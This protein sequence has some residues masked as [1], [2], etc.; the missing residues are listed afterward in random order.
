MALAGNFPAPAGN[1]QGPCPVPALP[2]E[3]LTRLPHLHREARRNFGEARLLAR[4]PAAAMLLMTA[5]ALV[6]LICGLPG[7]GVTIKAGFAWSALLL[8]GIAAMTRNYIRG[9]ARAL[10]RVPL[11]AAAADL[12]AIL[13]YTGLA[14]GAGA[15]LVMPV[16]AFA[17]AALAFAVLPPLALVLLLRDEGAAAAFTVPVALLGAGAALMQA[18]QAGLAAA[19]VTADLAVTFLPHL[20]RRGTHL[21]G[22]RLPAG[23]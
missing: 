7:E 16:T 23:R 13:L 2:R 11:P 17:A 12:R 15:Y 19:I 8:T 4:S 3:A 6:L 22:P 20:L 1:A 5:G 9:F 21:R 10:D 18:G 14:W